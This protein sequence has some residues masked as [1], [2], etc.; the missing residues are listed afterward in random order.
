M[1]TIRVFTAYFDIKELCIFSTDY[2]YVFRMI[3]IINREYVPKSFN[4]L[5]FIM[6]T[7][8]VSFEVE[9]EF[10]GRPVI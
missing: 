9:I 5:I 8:R 3:H 4:Q 6:G 7:Q 2:I 1:V 10:L